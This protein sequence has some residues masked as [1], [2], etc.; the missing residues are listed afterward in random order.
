MLIQFPGSI[1][2]GHCFAQAFMLLRGFCLEFANQPFCLKVLG[3]RCQAQSVAQRFVLVVL[4]EAV[5][6]SAVVAVV[7]ALAG[8]VVRSDGRR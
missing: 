5:A 8:L 4:S 3:C 1:A 7:A 2:V 6:V